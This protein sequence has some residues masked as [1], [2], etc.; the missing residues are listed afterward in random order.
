MPAV[1]HAKVVRKGWY[2][3]DRGAGIV[4]DLTCIHGLLD[5]V[6]ATHRTEFESAFGTGLVDALLAEW[7]ENGLR[8]REVPALVQ[9]FRKAA[10]EADS[11]GEVPVEFRNQRELPDVGAGVVPVLCAILDYLAG[12]CGPDG[13]VVLVGQDE[14]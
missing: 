9:R 1:I 8:S 13:A 12:R 4:A 2:E 11:L 3:H 7:K 14:R 6:C 5:E 10:F